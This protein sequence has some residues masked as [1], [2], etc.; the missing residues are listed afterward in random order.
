MT[1]PG[2]RLLA[3]TLLRLACLLAVVTLALAVGFFAGWG[4]H[5]TLATSSHHRWMPPP[6]PGDLAFYE[7]PT[8]SPTLPGVE[9][10]P[11]ALNGDRTLAPMMRSTAARAGDGQG[12]Q[13]SG[14]ATWYATGPDCL[15]A[16]AGPALRH[17]AWRGSTVT[18]NGLAVVLV[19]ACWCIARH[20]L[21]TLLDL[22]DEAFR[23]LTDPTWYPGQRDA[24]GDLVP[25]PLRRGVLRVVVTL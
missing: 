16:A 10:A 14:L 20:G 24:K 6:V 15:C 23:L 18:V 22:S 19:D 11:G 4:A 25:D 13:L 21:P 1:R 9:A 8:T 2:L 12:R 7:P 17:G 5:I 3:V